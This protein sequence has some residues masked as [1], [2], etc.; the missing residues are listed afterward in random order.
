MSHQKLRRNAKK[1]GLQTD[2]LENQENEYPM[3][4]NQENVIPNVFDAEK[5]LLNMKIPA[6]PESFMHRDGNRMVISHIEVENFKCYYGGQIIGPF[7]KSFTSIIGPNGSGKSNVIDSLLFVFGYRASKI[8]SKKSVHF[9]KTID[10]DKSEYKQVDGSNISV[11]RTAFKAV[12]DD[13]I[14]FSQLLS[15]IFDFGPRLFSKALASTTTN[16]QRRGRTDGHPKRMR[17]I[18]DG[19]AATKRIAGPCQK[20]I[21]NSEK[22]K[23]DAEAGIRTE[24]LTLASTERNVKKVNEKIHRLNQWCRNEEEMTLQKKVDELK[25]S[26]SQ[27]FPYEMACQCVVQRIGSDCLAS[28]EEKTLQL[29]TEDEEAAEDDEE[30]EDEGEEDGER[31]ELHEQMELEEDGTEDGQ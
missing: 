6:P 17:P 9:S 23:T 10:I 20:R 16:E 21:K 22:V 31:D 8:R 7:H 1:K 12:L 28:T 5:D 3:P 2:S 13:C 19:V 26:V 15:V 27:M 11:S 14:R 18:G 30:E 25:L 4:A 24:N 29:I